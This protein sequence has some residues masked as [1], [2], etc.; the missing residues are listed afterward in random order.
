VSCPDRQYGRHW[1][2]LAEVL[3]DKSEDQC[4][5]FFYNQRKRYQLDKIVHEFKKVRGLLGAFL[6]L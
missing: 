1:E 3:P 6:L 4:K 2:R 5:Q